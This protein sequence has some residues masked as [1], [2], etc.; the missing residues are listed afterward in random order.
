MPTVTLTEAN[1]PKDLLFRTKC[2]YLYHLN[3]SLL[4]VISLIVFED[5]KKAA[6]FIGNSL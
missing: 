2:Q 1:T 3:K 6:Q 4:P 5:F